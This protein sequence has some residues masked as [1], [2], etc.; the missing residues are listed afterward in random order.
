MV[1]KHKE[2]IMGGM[3]EKGADILGVGNSANHITTQKYD[4]KKGN[5]G[6][7]MGSL[8]SAGVKQNADGTWSKV[9]NQGANDVTRNNLQTGMLSGIE[10]NPTDAQDAYYNS[11][12]RMVEP[13]FQ[14]AQSDLDENLINRGIQVGG[15]QYS[16]AMQNLLNSQNTTR[17]NAADSAM[18]SGQNYT[19]QQI[20]NVN[21]LGAGRDVNTIASLLGE[22]TAYN[23]KNAADSARNAEGEAYKNQR[24]NNIMGFFGM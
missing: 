4:M 16:T 2:Y 9:F 24:S 17:Q 23:N 7:D 20:Q 14:K 8:G 10:S 22:N 1:E 5:L 12:M 15:N 11:Q 6:V 19:G 3:I 21:Q 13:Q 18:M